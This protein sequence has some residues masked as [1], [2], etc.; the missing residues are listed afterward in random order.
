MFVELIASAIK[1]A[2]HNTYL[3]HIQQ[4]LD[5][6]DFKE[7]YHNFGMPPFNDALKV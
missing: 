2:L 5:S 6:I 1:N 4:I 3:C 7:R